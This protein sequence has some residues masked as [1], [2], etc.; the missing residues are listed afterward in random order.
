[1]LNACQS[2]V[3]KAAIVLVV[4]PAIWAVDREAMI[5]VISESFEAG[6]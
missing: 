6:A 5:V 3:V 1:V 2:S 4:I